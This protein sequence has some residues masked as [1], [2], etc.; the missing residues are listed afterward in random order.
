MFVAGGFAEVNEQRLH[1]A[2]RGGR[3]GRGDRPRGGAPPRSRTPRR[4]SRE[5]KDDADRA[6]RRARDRRSPRRRSRP[7]AAERSRGAQPRLAG[8][9]RP[10]DR[11]RRGSHR[12]AGD[13]V[14]VAIGRQVVL[15]D[16]VW[17]M[18][19]GALR[20]ETPPTPSVVSRRLA[21]RHQQATGVVEV[22]QGEVIEKV[23]TR[24]LCRRADRAGQE[25]VWLSRSVR[26]ARSC[27]EQIGAVRQELAGADRRGRAGAGPRGRQHPD[28]D[29]RLQDR[30]D[31]GHQPADVLDERLPRRAPGRRCW[32]C[33]AC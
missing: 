11:Q 1:R 30:A 2:G 29:R 19:I 3:A 23:A 31:A 27:A 13:T 17:V 15:R 22:V 5:A 7:P 8:T 32:G 26:Y 9:D 20:I 14:Y 24:E 21:S 33:A 6:R 18:L 25:R 28:R 4:I 16:V 10:H 12:A